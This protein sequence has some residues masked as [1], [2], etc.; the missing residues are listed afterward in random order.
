MH[1]AMS[2]RQQ[3]NA[4]G[5]QCTCDCK[6]ARVLFCEGLQR[7]WALDAQAAPD[8]RARDA[9]RSPRA[10]VLVATQ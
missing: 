2:M 7:T 6:L 5:H 1:V 3:T 4:K 9:T 10:K 8:Q